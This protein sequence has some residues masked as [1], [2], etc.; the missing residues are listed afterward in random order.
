MKK[1]S[2]SSL[3]ACIM[4]ESRAHDGGLREVSQMKEDLKDRTG[5]ISPGDDRPQ[6]HTPR[7]PE[8]IALLCEWL[9]DDSGYDEQVW[10]SVKRGLEDNRLSDRS[11]FRG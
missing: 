11:R 7:E 3:P 2:F 10:P 8:A 1:N 4:K 6:G 5:D 9:S